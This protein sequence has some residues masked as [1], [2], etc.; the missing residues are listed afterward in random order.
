VVVVAPDRL[1]AWRGTLVPDF[2]NALLVEGGEQ[3]HESVRAGV[4]AAA[5]LGAEIVAVHDAARPLVDARDVTAVVRALGRADAAILVAPVT[6]T[7]K[8]VGAD[9]AVVETLNRQDLRLALTPQ[10]FRVASLVEAWTLTGLDGE[11]SDE[12]SFLEQSGF[13]VRSVVAQHL[14]PKLTTESDLR[15]MRCLCKAEV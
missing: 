13:E 9:G 1:D 2:P 5:E 8:R 6:D 3:R 7:V 14:N 4:L 10:V 12:S 15:L 11:W